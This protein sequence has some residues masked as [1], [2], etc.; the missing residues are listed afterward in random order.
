[1]L[2]ATT[3]LLLQSPVF[4]S[5]DTLAGLKLL[6][7]LIEDKDYP[8]EMSIQTTQYGWIALGQVEHVYYNHVETLE[9]YSKVM[10]LATNLFVTSIH[11]RGIGNKTCIP[12]RDYLKGEDVQFTSKWGLN[13]ESV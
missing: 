2:V 10:T 12:R 3:K 9:F 13:S 1:M 8:V 6:V 7:K 11:I 5:Y 4:S